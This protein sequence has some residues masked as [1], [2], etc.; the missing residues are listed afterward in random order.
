[1]IAE[2]GSALDY[3]A[4]D[5]DPVNSA[6]IFSETCGCLD[7]DKLYDCIKDKDAADLA[8]CTSLMVVGCIIRTELAL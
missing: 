4:I 1:M 8:V 7:P 6:N 3:W 5:D 2:S